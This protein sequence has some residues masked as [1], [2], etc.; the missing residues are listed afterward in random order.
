M[1]CSSC[2]QDNRT[3]R[4]FC[5]QCGAPL[6]VACPRCGAV[7]EPGERFCGRCG[8]SLE[9]GAAAIRMP[10]PQPSPALPSSFAGG[11]YQVKDFLGEGGRK[12]VYLAHDTKLDRDVALAAIK[13]EGLNAEGL[14]R[15]RREAQAM[16]RLG[17]HPN[18][19]TVFDIGE[20]EG[21]PY[22]VSQYMAGGDL[23]GLLNAAPRRQLPVEQ[24]LLIAEQV[25]Q[26]LDHAHSQ[27]IVHRDLKPGN[28]WLTDAGTAKIGDFGLAVALDRSR[29][30]MQGMMV[31]TVGYMPPEQAL[32]RQSDPRSDLYSLG[33][34]LYEMATG[35]PPFLGEDAVAVISQHINTAPVAPSYHSPLVPRALEA[36]IL[37]LLAK[38]PGERPQ[39]APPVAAELR[40][41][42]ESASQLASLEQQTAA[43]PG[44]AELQGVAWGAFVGRRA[45]MEQLK[46]AL[47]NVLSGRGSLVMLVGEPGIGKTRL[48]QEFAVYA[49]LRGAQVLSGHCY[50]G[51]ASVPYL[52]WTEAFRAYVQARPDTAL[53]EELGEGAPDVATLVSEIRQ[54]YP[55][56][57]QPPQLEG[58]AARHRLFEGV[59]EFVRNAAAA[60]PLLI[61]LDDIHWADKPSLLLLQHLARGIAGQRVLIV[62]AYRD[63]ELDRTHPLSEIVATLRRE[64][65]YQ[66]VLLRG[67]PEDDVVAFVAAVSEQQPTDEQAQAGRR[68]LAAALCRETE[69]N[70]FF[71]REILTHLVE[72]GK[73]YRDEEGRWTAGGITNISELGIPE[74][75]REV[76]GRRL[77]RLSEGCNRMVTLASTMTGGFSWE[78]L[79]AI[80]A[81]PEAQL[82]DLLDEALRAQLV[83]ERRDG[84]AVV[85]EFTHALIRQ[86][87]YGEL[88]TPRRVIL[89]RQ[90]GEAL[91]KLYESNAEPHLAELAHHFYQAA[92]GGD[93]NKAIDFARR[94]GERAME[95][96]AYEDAV[97]QY[98][99]ALQALDL[100]AHTDTAARCDLLLALAQAQGSAG[101]IFIGRE[102]ALR[103]AELARRL[104][105]AQRFGDAVWL[106]GIGLDTGNIDLQF[107]GRIEEALARLGE[108]DSGLTARLMARL[109]NALAFGGDQE[110]R[111]T[112]AR[113][114]LEMA[115][116]AGDVDALVYTMTNTFMLGFG[117]E[118]PR[119]QLT[120]ADEIVTLAEAS[121][122]E[123]GAIWGHFNR[124]ACYLEMGDIPAVEQEMQMHRRLAEKLRQ[125]FFAWFGPL[126]DCMRALLDGQWEEG[127]R[128][129]QQALA[130]GQSP[131]GQNAVSMFGAQMFPL[132]RE[133]G[134]LSELEGA[135]KAFVAQY[136]NLW[137]WHA[138][139]GYG[140]CDLARLDEARAVFEHYAGRLE[141]MPRDWAWLIGMALLAEL[142][143]NLGDIERAS[144][145]YDLLLPY[146]GRNVIVGAN[147]HCYGDTSR[148]LGQ[149]ATVLEWWEE[150]EEHYNHALEMNGRMS[151]PWLA[152]TQYQYADMLFRRDAPGDREKALLLVSQALDIAERLSMKTLLERVLAFKLKAQGI[153]SSDLQTSIDTVVR[154][155][156]IEQPDLR[157]HAAPDG[158]VTIMFSDIEGS[159]EK[160]ERLGD[161][162]WMQVLR[163]HNAIVREKLKA[164]GGFEVKSEGDGFMVAF[165]SAA[166]A[167]Q[168]AIAVQQ[169]LARRNGGAEVPIRV[170]MGLH[171]GEVIKEG[172]DFF[173]KNVILAARIAGQAKGGEILVSS[174]LKELT[175][176]AGEFAFDDG[177]QTEL[178][179]LSGRHRVFAV[180]QQ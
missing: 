4:S 178:K 131:H 41:I 77:S 12:R 36:L 54:R 102:T 38:A 134:R 101:S 64:R 83:H 60:N 15:V 147:A 155:V 118:D 115:R 66:R 91:E 13:T 44:A 132:R 141:S 86:T 156:Y 8:T 24:A 168:C 47:E 152:W 124:I 40:R 126:L 161:K 16:G 96:F 59:G 166:R 39:S 42:A 98:E 20:E 33:C 84:Q 107:V 76:I 49:S 125:P 142:C 17:D 82:L 150:A 130:I 167:L 145:L 5:A 148:F 50:E 163:E 28:I 100:R 175:E 137:P 179:G 23:E 62:G 169:A 75:V 135:V 108:A 27:G 112:L 89:H 157:S 57:P 173:G 65:P 119:K 2:G 165:Q 3:E 127:E 139:L 149:L 81:E 90:I 117:H 78:A 14:V 159:T 171:T 129:A 162:G 69:G 52:P 87:L 95:S 94:A 61:F 72:E 70:P 85:Y 56:L 51:E 1:L 121:G 30:T 92:P 73:L 105:D 180:R 71:I 18:I 43:A 138:A 26:G 151:P 32:G 140:Y 35:R 133:Q 109:S 53:R 88:S 104:S 123:V 97:G 80:C 143:W 110:R 34:I 176:S 19:V 74:G 172:E 144:R 160:T 79:K 106:S 111:T 113:E 146:A 68:L 31:G 122:R 153:E 116:R 154:T 177:R 58:E 37:R 46:G 9:A 114:A 48:A 93:V 11:R 55:D 174:L 67:L 120:A 99:R 103:A 158:T 164:H 21:Q 6:T 170:R 128:L 7:N 29:L 136:P 22:I 45:E 63:I 25:C 10:T